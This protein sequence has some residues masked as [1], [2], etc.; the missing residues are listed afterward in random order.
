MYDKADHETTIRIPGFPEND[1]MHLSV[2][3]SGTP[4]AGTIFASDPVSSSRLWQVATDGTITAI[5]TGG[6]VRSVAVAPA[7]TPNAGDVYV[8]HKETGTVTKIDLKDGVSTFPAGKSPDGLVVA[9]AGAPDSGTVYVAD[10]DENDATTVTLL[11]PNGASA[12]IDLGAPP[13]HFVFGPASNGQRTLFVTTNT[14]CDCR[15]Q[16]SVALVRNEK[17]VTK[18]SLGYEDSQLVVAPNGAPNAGTAYAVAETQDEA[19][20]FA[21]DGV[22]SVSPQGAASLIPGTVG[23]EVGSLAVVGAGGPSPGMVYAATRTSALRILADGTTTAVA[24]SVPVQ[25]GSTVTV[26]PG[27]LT[28]SSR[29]FIIN[30]GSQ[31]GTVDVVDPPNGAFKSAFRVATPVHPS[32]AVVRTIPVKPTGVGGELDVL[33]NLKDGGFNGQPGYADLVRITP[34]VNAESLH[35][36]GLASQEQP[37]VI[38]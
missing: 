18:V 26:I 34:Q 11:K 33:A 37:I 25:G 21:S 1:A 36:P 10:G 30:Y 31:P 2:S 29:A 5:D 28:N 27:G 22:M 13:D 19:A 9:P 24:R 12:S 16:V 38:S 8:T 3:P 7:G 15:G 20:G 35:L 14:G 32:F 6:V 4:N 23:A 17:L